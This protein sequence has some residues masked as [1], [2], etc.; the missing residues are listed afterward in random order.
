MYL[1]MCW[2]YSLKSTR[3]TLIGGLVKNVFS[4]VTQVFSLGIIPSICI[5]PV[6]CYHRVMLQIEVY[7]SIYVYCQ[8][9]G[10][11]PFS[12]RNGLRE[13]TRIAS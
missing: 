10:L 5:T 1:G 7:E 8:L 11:S 3:R 4:P 6:Y 13:D 9:S 2:T 12:S